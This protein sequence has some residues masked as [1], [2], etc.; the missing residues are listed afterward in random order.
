MIETMLQIATGV[1]VLLRRVSDIKLPQPD[2]YE[3]I[4]DNLRG[5]I[6]DLQ[7]GGRDRR[8]RTVDIDLDEDD[9][10]YRLAGINVPDLEQ[11]KL[12]YGVGL[13]TS[14]IAWQ[15]AHVVPLDTFA[16]HFDQGYVAAAFYD[17]DKVKL[18]L[19]P[20]AVAS[21]CWRLT[22]R[23]P[24]LAIIEEGAVIPLPSDFVPML[25]KE[26]AVACEPLVRD[27]SEQWIAWTLRTMPKYR[28][29]ILAWNNPNWRGNGMAPG[30]WQHYLVSSNEPQIQNIRPSNSAR[31]NASGRVNPR[32][33]LPQ[34]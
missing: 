32:G 14:T 9:I 31:R 6:Q 10:D 26:V 12:E 23:E 19:D 5:K 34:Q 33:F 29:D 27:D 17:E 18:N 22:Y 8:T 3:Q 7:I 11:A 2:I 24:L 30:R 25:K 20:N 15:E 4:N 16:R 13:T 1:R 21:Y 28:T